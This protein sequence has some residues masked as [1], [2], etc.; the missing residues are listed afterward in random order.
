MSALQ[1]QGLPPEA[2]SVWVAPAEG[3]L[4][5]LQH[6]SE[7]LRPAASVMKLFTTGAALRTLGPA[8]TWQTHVA[9]TGTLQANGT[10]S[11]SVHVRGSGGPKP[12]HGA[13]V[14]DAVAL[15]GGRTASH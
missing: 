1:A 6:L 15:V 7:T 14:P 4:P 11:G 10:L 13:G 3:G 9:L 5:R 2:L 8:W 12:A